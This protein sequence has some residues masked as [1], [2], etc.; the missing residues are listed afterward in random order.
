MHLG[1]EPVAKESPNEINLFIS[2]GYMAYGYEACINTTQQV[3]G[4]GKR[5]AKES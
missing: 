2:T 1:N 5:S 4:R 3:A